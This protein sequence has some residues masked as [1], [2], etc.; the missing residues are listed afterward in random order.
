MFF[1]RPNDCVWK[2]EEG[3]TRLT[4][5]Y[6]FYWPLGCIRK[7]GLQSSHD[8]DDDDDNV[9]GVKECTWDLI[10]RFPYVRRKC[11]IYHVIIII[12][13]VLTAK[14]VLSCHLF[15]N[16]S[17]ASMT[18][19]KRYGER[20]RNN[21]IWDDDLAVTKVFLVTRMR[22]D[23]YNMGFSWNTINCRQAHI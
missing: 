16:R 10:R 8:D 9:G 20:G 23:F 21:G 2:Q 4:N 5:F 19:E 12:V 17:S 22:S 1:Y 11:V 15:S 3:K 6:V 14:C 18:N 7:S 13:V